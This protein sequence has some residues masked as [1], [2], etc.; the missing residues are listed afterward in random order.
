MYVALALVNFFES[1]CPRLIA[2]HQ[3]FYQNFCSEWRF[4]FRI[5]HRLVFTGTNFYTTKTIDNVS[6]WHAGRGRI[7]LHSRDT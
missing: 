2:I 4:S 7:K 6:L 1:L 5:D 3:I